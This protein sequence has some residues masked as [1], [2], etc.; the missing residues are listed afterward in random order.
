MTG[1]DN[2]EHLTKLIL[3]HRNMILG[4]ILLHVSH[5]NESEDLFQDVCTTIVRKY[6]GE[7]EI[8]N[9]KAWAMQ[10][11]RYK[12]GAHFQS[13]GSKP[14]TVP[15]NDDLM[16][17]LC[18]IVLFGLPREIA[19][20]VIIDHRTGGVKDRRAGEKV[21]GNRSGSM[22]DDLRLMIWSQVRAPLG[23]HR[24]CVLSALCG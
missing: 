18:D 20:S 14:E 9:F 6:P 4:F 12:V 24:L 1:N 15:L 3:E 16:N 13:K 7:Q 19:T 11:T 10:I 23:L 22:I 17:T 2:Q 21:K 5:F 8:G